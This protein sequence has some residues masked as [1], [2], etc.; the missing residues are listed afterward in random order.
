MHSW[1][2]S[3]IR[4]VLDYSPASC[5]SSDAHKNKMISPNNTCHFT[6]F[7][8]TYMSFLGTVFSWAAEFHTKFVHFK[9]GSFTFCVAKW[10][11]RLGSGSNL[12]I[13]WMITNTADI[14]VFNGVKQ[15]H[16]CHISL[17]LL[18]PLTLHCRTSPVPPQS[19][20]HL[21]VISCFLTVSKHSCAALL[22]QWALCNVRPRYCVAVR[23]TMAQEWCVQ[24]FSWWYDLSSG[25]WSSWETNWLPVKL[26][27]ILFYVEMKQLVSN[28]LADRQEKRKFPG[29][30][31]W[32]H[33]L[34][35]F[36]Y[37][38]AFHR[39]NNESN[40]NEIKI[41]VRCHPNFIYLKAEE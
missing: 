33:H 5:L 14:A 10:H 18:V 21:P 13:T 31:C 24:H 35:N 19:S 4:T 39:L 26:P 8:I 25:D 29:S 27:F 20:G 3:Y 32:K 23:R 15:P 28:W 16:W 6:N 38:L 40:G 37:F 7:T 11:G 12:I 9:T 34:H 17:K 2:L 1:V 36:L 30:S 22:L 41:I